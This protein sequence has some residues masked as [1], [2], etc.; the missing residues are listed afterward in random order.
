M[1]NSQVKR[2]EEGSGMSGFHCYSCGPDRVPATHVI[3]KYYMNGTE[4]SRTFCPAHTSKECKQIGLK[5]P[6]MILPENERE[7]EIARIAC[8]QMASRLREGAGISATDMIINQLYPKAIKYREFTDV[9]TGD[10]YRSDG[11][12]LQRRQSGMG[13]V[14]EWVPFEPRLSSSRR[15]VADVAT[16]YRG[17][18]DIIEHPIEGK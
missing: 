7:I 12:L 9:P 17:M 10:V 8:M 6:M 15:G 4:E 18:L 13:G 3:T 11:N 5:D 1:S 16:F 14:V 2:I